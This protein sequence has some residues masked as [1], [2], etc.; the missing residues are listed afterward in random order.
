MPGA[1]YQPCNNH[2]T[3]RFS[4]CHTFSHAQYLIQLCQGSSDTS[5]FSALQQPQHTQG[6]AS[7][8]LSDMLGHAIATAH[9]RF[10]LC[11]SFRHTELPGAASQHCNSHSEPK[12][13]PLSQPETCSVQMLLSS[14]GCSTQCCS[15]YGF[16]LSASSHLVTTCAAPAPAACGA[17]I[18]ASLMC[19]GDFKCL[20][21][22]QVV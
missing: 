15:S 18:I 2:S 9:P 21:L 10:S 11:H 8:S 20:T 7:V 5:C 17:V 6:S 1:A 12:A 14:H 4:L 16:Q 3:P 13:Q 22:C 19:F